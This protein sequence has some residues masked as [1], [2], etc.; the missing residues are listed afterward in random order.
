MVIRRDL[1]TPT[2]KEEIHRYSSQCS[3]RLNAHPNDLLVNLTTRQQQAIV[4]KPAYLRSHDIGGRNPNIM[5]NGTNWKY[6]N[7]LSLLGSTALSLGP[8][9]LFSFPNLKQSR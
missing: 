6:V 1:Q 8:G 7:E 4:K 2:V 9:L 3:V 5:E